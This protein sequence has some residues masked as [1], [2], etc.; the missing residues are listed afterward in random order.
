MR[1][2]LISF[3]LTLLLFSCNSRNQ[4]DANNNEARVKKVNDYQMMAILYNYYAAEYKALTNQAFNTAID[5]LQQIRA[6]EPRRKNLAVVVD[7]D[8]TILDNSPYQAKL[9]ELNTTYDSCWNTWCNLASARAVP[10]AVEFLKYADSLGFSVFY[11]SNRKKVLEDATIKNLQKLGF[12]QLSGDHFYLRTRDS[13]KEARR[14]TIAEKYE[15]V[16]LAGDNLGDFYSDTHEYLQ[17]DSIV[18]ARRKDFGRKF[19][20]LPNAMYGNWPASL[21]IK[22]N[23]FPADSLLKKM[24]ENFNGTCN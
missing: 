20:M 12:P 14:N 22:R 23:Q 10:G 7:I 13:G 17:R 8:E 9:L 15:I 16:L 21:G 11:V 1:S 6:K 5:R 18:E 3:S 19:I 2:I 24:T 4:S